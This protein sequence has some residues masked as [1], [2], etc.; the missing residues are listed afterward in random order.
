MPSAHSAGADFVLLDGSASQVNLALAER[1][2]ERNFRIGPSSRGYNDDS[3]L[4]L[5]EAF[6][7]VGLR[8]YP[9][10]HL[11]AK[12]QGNE[13]ID[14]QVFNCRVIRTPHRML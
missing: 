8:P 9:V 2:L 12:R 3:Y 1:G 11:A 10:A 6:D 7:G 14:V 5:V 4:H 13:L